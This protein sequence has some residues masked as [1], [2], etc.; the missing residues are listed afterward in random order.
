M[1]R[2]NSQGWGETYPSLRHFAAPSRMPPVAEPD[3]SRDANLLLR[4]PPIQISLPAKMARSQE[5]IDQAQM[6]FDEQLTHLGLGPENAWEARMVSPATRL[7]RRLA[8][9]V[10]SVGTLLLGELSNAR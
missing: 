9:L 1:R 2:S 10:Y 7:R 4:D 5:N 3:R 8:S 6:R